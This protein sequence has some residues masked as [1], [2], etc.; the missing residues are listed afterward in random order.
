MDPKDIV[1]RCTQCDHEVTREVQDRGLRCC[2]KCETTSLPCDPADDV[3]VKVNWHELRILVM[4]SERWASLDGIPKDE[5]ESMLRTVR[6]I[7]RRISAQHADRAGK[8]P[9]TFLGEIKQLRDA[10]GKVEQNVVRE[11]E[12]PLYPPTDKDLP[13]EIHDLLNGGDE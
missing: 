3:E 6:A 11:E 9:L 10:F 5:S 4:W 8:L 13:G 2:P 7:A 12:P 1:A